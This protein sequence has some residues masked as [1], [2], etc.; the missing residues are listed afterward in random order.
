MKADIPCLGQW[1]WPASGQKLL[2]TLGSCVLWLTLWKADPV[3]QTTPTK[4]LQQNPQMNPSCLSLPSYR[5]ARL[6]DPPQASILACQPAPTA[7]VGASRAQ[8]E[9]ISLLAQPQ[10]TGTFPEVSQHLSDNLT[11]LGGAS[12]PLRPT[13]SRPLPGLQSGSERVK[14]H[15]CIKSGPRLWPLPYC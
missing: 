11:A 14:R 10:P 7:G 4:C 6:P 13:P 5:Q 9:A 2:I 1:P 8:A 15:S 3:W 12:L